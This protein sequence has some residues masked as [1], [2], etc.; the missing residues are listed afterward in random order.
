M[1]F[2]VQSELDAPLSASS[3]QQPSGK[4]R[5]DKALPITRQMVTSK[6]AA[7]LHHEIPLGDLVDW[8]QMAMM[9]GEFEGVDRDALHDTV[10]RLGLANVRTFG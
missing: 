6:L 3:V 2:A 9:E 5:S 1:R 7:Y 4:L 8:G 10:S